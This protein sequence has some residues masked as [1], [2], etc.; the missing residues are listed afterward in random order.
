MVADVASRCV[1]VCFCP[2]VL[3]HRV[4]IDACSL[5]PGVSSGHPTS[6]SRVIVAVNIALFTGTLVCDVCDCPRNHQS[7]SIVLL[8]VESLPVQ[9]RR[10][11]VLIETIICI[12]PTSI[13]SLATRSP[14]TEQASH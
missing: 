11:E 3:A 8:L 10:C 1:I 4:H 6:R 5:S 2:S 12:L 13:G 14:I 9:G 7:M